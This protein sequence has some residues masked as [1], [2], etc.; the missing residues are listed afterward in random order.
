MSE[1]TPSPRK[2]AS[3]KIPRKKASAKADQGTESP[4]KTVD[5]IR[6]TDEQRASLSL[7]EGK[8]GVKR[9]QVVR[10]A[11]DALIEKWNKDGSLVLP[12]T[13]SDSPEDRQQGSR[14]AEGS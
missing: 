8:L 10:W 6:L 1:N 2:K 3:Y 9:A 11:V 4:T 12:L 7:I 5:A 13:F 14:V